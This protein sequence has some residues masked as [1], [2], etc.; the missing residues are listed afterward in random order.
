MSLIV[1]LYGEDLKLGK[2]QLVLETIGD[3][4]RL[5][6][7]PRHDPVGKG[8]EA[9]IVREI[10][11]YLALSGG[12]AMIFG[13]GSAREKV[14]PADEELNVAGKVIGFQFKRPYLS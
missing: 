11:D 12:N 4:E 10:E 1:R 7:D 13:V 9:W 5:S 14:W 8:I 6:S 3:G 2:G